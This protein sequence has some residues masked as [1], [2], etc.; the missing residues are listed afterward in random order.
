MIKGIEGL[1]KPLSLYLPANKLVNLKKSPD[2]D[3]ELPSPILLATHAA[4]AQI[5]YAADVTGE[6][7]NLL[8]EF[9]KLLYVPHLFYDGRTDLAECFFILLISKH[10]WHREFF[11]SFF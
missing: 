5:L 10:H 1:S 6:I 3:I 7:D 9:G 8:N 11:L 2:E 4:I